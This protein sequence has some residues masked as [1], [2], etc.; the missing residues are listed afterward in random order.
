MNKA[1]L[2]LA[3]LLASG[4]AHAD[5]LTHI[6]R[7]PTETVTL[8]DMPCKAPGRSWTKTV[9]H[10]A[11]SPEYGYSYGCFTISGGDVHIDWYKVANRRDLPEVVPGRDFQ[12]ISN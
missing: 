1:A 3:A 4:A 2:L 10:V 12:R 9:I 6:A 8:T 11:Y 7:Y 5:N